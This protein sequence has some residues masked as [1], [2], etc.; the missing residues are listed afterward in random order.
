MSGNEEEAPAV[1]G[2]ESVLNTILQ[3]LQSLTLEIRQNR[4]EQDVQRR[5]IDQVF[6]I[7]E[8]RQILDANSRGIVAENPFQDDPRDESIHA[9]D[10]LANLKPCLLGWNKTSF[11]DIHTRKN[12]LTARISIVQRALTSRVTSRLLLLETDLQNEMNLVLQQEE[13]L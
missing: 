2:N 6:H 5:R 9:K 13:E 11:G 8:T 1:T 12:K 3:N 7:L 4:H 10:A